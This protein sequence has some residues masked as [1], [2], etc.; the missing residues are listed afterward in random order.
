MIV[1]SCTFHRKGTPLIELE[2]KD[3]IAT[4]TMNNPKNHNALGMEMR[5]KLGEFLLDIEVNPDVR[6]VVLKGAGKH[7]MS[8]GDVKK[9][10]ELVDEKTKPELRTEF[11]GRVHKL[12]HIMMALRRMPKPIIASVQGGAAGAGVSMA[13]SCDM[14]IASEKAFFVLAYCH[15]GTSPDGAATFQLP[16]TIGLKKTMEMALLGERMT[17]EEAKDIGMINR[18]VPHED[19]EKEITDVEKNVYGR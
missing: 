16:R 18:V 15:I 2:I 7:F 8:G 6:C 19:L 5:E 11:M 12:N 17:A 4:L 3:H 10:V 14:V 13:L 1:E 9:F